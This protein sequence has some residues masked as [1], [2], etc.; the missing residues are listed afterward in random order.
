[1]ANSVKIGDKVRFINATGGGIVRKFQSKNVIL[2]E[3]EDGF[4]TP[5]LISEV[6]VVQE[7]DK[8]NFPIEEKKQK[9]EEYT[10]TTPTPQKEEE[11]RWDENEETREGEELSLYLAYIPADIKNLQTT[12]T[13]LYLVND[14]N[15]FLDFCI[16][17]KEDD[18]YTLKYHDTIEPQTT[19][20]LNKI[21][22]ESV[23]EYEELKF[24]A[25]AYKR[26]SFVSKPSIDVTLKQNP[27][28][29]Y[30]LHSFKETEFFDKPAML[31]T[32]IYHDVVDLNTMLSTEQIQEALNSREKEENNRKKRI[33]KKRDKNE[34]IELD[35]HINELLDNTAGMSRGDMLKYQVEEAEKLIKQHLKHKGQKIVLIHG[36]GEGILRAEIEKMLKHKYKNCEYRDAS[37]Q[38]YGFGATMVIIH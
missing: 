16:Q 22:K 21:A 19:L 32:I 37:F 35:L 23:N 25:F 5:T 28:K 9:E 4:E 3:E 20:W 7:T 14:S 15:Y 6:V 2:V 11:Y 34:I 29:F 12:D 30:K 10:N 18:K 27:I 13:D 1:M 31:Q 24:Q 38:Q 36:K 33:E 17:A 8:Y 26:T